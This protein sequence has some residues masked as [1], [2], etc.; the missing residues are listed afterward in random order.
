MTLPSNL[1]GPMTKPVRKL[2]RSK[3]G[4]MVAGVAQGMA[5]YFDIDVI[6]FRLVWVFLLIPGGLPGFI[7][8][9]ICWIVIP[10]EK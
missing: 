6:W 8:Y 2:R 7:P 9:I 1:K 3:D 10:R 5:N 4:A